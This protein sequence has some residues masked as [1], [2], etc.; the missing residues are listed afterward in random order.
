MKKST[1]FFFLAFIISMVLNAKDYNIIDFGAKNDTSVTST[2]AI[3][4][5]IDTCYS[6][7]GGKVVIPSGFFKSGTIVLKSNV[8]LYFE[9]GATLYA[10]TDPKDFPRQKQPEYRSLKDKGHW[11]ALIYAESADKISIRGNGTINGQGEK[12]LPHPDLFG[13]DMDGRP[14][15]ILFISCQNIIVEGITM[16]NS[17]M[18]NQHYL[19]C[20]DVKVKD[21]TVYNHS[22]RNNDGIDIDGCRRFLL[23]NSIFDTDDDAICLKSTGEASCK[24]VVITNCIISS[25]CNAIKCGTESTGGFENIIISNC[26]VTPSKSSS[27]TIF[28]SPKHGWTGI[29]L[30][31]VDG[32][33]MNN[34]NVNSI[35]IEGTE[36]PIYVRLAN[37]ARKHIAEATD[38]KVGVMKNIQ[39]SNIT[40]YN[41]GNFS[42]SITGVS[43]A[44][45]E[46]IS[47][48][49]IK[50]INK[51]GLK[52]GEYISNIDSIS[53]DEKGYPQP[54]IWGNLPSYGFFIRHVQNIELNGIELSSDNKENRYPIIVVDVRKLILRGL[55][56]DLSPGKKNVLVKEVTEISTDESVTFEKF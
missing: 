20:E 32:G 15:N 54:N 41:T 22:N 7:G 12:Q 26:I 52:P 28:S 40:A 45:I 4:K 49:N 19:D 3:N 17:G 24:N 23:S 42:S 13:S 51:G 1:P 55:Q 37:R 5:A 39:I 50:F 36:C 10:S 31:I 48:R 21:I 2:I 18:W 11:F 44:K 35:T 34:V 27:Q 53:E 29:S 33:I 16:I 9:T 30:E 56:T 43:G 25:H 8:E 47:L 6:T 38:P 46:N 14:R